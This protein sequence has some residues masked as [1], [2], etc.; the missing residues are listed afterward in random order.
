MSGGVRRDYQNH[1]GFSILFSSS[2][3]TTQWAASISGD[4]LE[5]IIP[6]QGGCQVVSLSVWI[7]YLSE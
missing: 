1:V 3:L 2:Y 4:G 5:S 7:F 6:H